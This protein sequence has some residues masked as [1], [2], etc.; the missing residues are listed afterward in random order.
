VN[1]GSFICKVFQGAGTDAF[2]GDV[3]R[4]FGTVKAMK[5][6]ASRSGSSEIYLVARNYHL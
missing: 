6:K 5:P 4:S 2:I 1:N 3:R